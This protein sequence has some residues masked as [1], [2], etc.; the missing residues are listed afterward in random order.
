MSKVMI[1]GDIHG[2]FANLETIVNYGFKQHSIEACIVCG[3]YGIWNDITHINLIPE[4]YKL[5][6]KVPVYFCDGNHD[7]HYFLDTFERGK[8]HKL[9]ENLYFCAYG[10]VLTINNKN[11]LFCGG[12]DSIDKEQRILGKSY[13]DTEQI[14]EED[15]NF[16]PDVHIDIVISHTCP[17]FIA[18]ILKIP[19]CGLYINKYY[20]PSTKYLEDVY[21]KYKPE[22]WYFGH[23]HVNWSNYNFTALNMIPYKNYIEVLPKDIQSKYCE[24][25]NGDVYTIIN[26]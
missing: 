5:D 10:S 21:I 11:I 16:L 17:N 15:Q 26:L 18:S 12:A 23:W 13:W 22:H 20:D 14:S 24:S 2:K 9:L 6:V 7:N 8:I 1:I 25:L 19:T 3:D 4:Y